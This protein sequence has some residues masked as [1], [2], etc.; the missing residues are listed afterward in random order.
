MKRKLRLP[1]REALEHVRKARVAT[2]EELFK[3]VALTESINKVIVSSGNKKIYEGLVEELPED[4]LKGDI[5]GFDVANGFLMCNVDPITA[6]VDTPVA[7]VLNCFIDDTTTKI[8]VWD[9]D[10]SEE[11]F[12]GTKAEVLQK[13]G[14]C[15]LIS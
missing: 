8:V 14:H 12:Q 13:F 1:T 2:T 9:A 6:D 15:Q 5:E 10:T 4:I 3:K 11:L 7:K